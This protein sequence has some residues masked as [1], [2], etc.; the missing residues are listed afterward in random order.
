MFLLEKAHQIGN[1]YYHVL[2]GVD[3]PLKTMRQ[4]HEFFERHK[5][6]E[7]LSYN[8]EQLHND[9]EVIRRTKYYHLLQ[10]YRRRFKIKIYNNF[11]TFF[12]RVLLVLQMCFKFNRTRYLDWQIKYGSNWVSI[13]NLLAGDVLKNKDKIK[14]I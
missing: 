8:E 1:D 12:S 14:N 10:N 2:S 4:I 3:T 9:P 13:T 5:G 11:F 6:Q 7:F